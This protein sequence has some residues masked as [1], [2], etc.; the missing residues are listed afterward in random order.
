[1][2]KI[3]NFRVL[4]NMTNPFLSKVIVNYLIIQYPKILCRICNTDTKKQTI[5][6]QIQKEFYK[7]LF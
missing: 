7:P 5:T 2:I 3:T 6:Q 1:M 4:F